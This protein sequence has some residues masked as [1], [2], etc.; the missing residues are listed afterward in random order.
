V[1]LFFSVVSF[2][3]VDGSPNHV[4]PRSPRGPDRSSPPSPAGSPTATTEKS[5]VASSMV[6]E[7][8]KRI[9][10]SS[11]TDSSNDTEGRSRSNPPPPPP[12]PISRWKNTSAL[13]RPVADSTAA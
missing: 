4:F 10:V 9:F 2:P 5:D 8:R 12:S 13:T 7:A 3:E 11:F 1:V 6:T